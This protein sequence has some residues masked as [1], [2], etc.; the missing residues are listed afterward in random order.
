[1]KDHIPPAYITEM[2]GRIQT[3]Q[4]RIKVRLDIAKQDAMAGNTWAMIRNTAEARRLE[5]LLFER[6]NK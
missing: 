1:M 3:L 2:G 5:V 6:L 4:A